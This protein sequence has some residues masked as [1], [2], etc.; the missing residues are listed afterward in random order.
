MAPVMLDF[1]ELGVAALFNMPPTE[2][3]TGQRGDGGEMKHAG[4]KKRRGW[5]QVKRQRGRRRWG[6]EDVWRRDGVRGIKVQKYN[7]GDKMRVREKPTK[8]KVQRRK[9]G[10][11]TSET[12]GL[13]WKKRSKWEVEAWE[14]D[15]RRGGNKWRRERVN[16]QW[17]RKWELSPQICVRCEGE[18]EEE[19][20]AE[21]PG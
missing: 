19:G 16:K 13:K 8:R 6:K 12:R 3:A 17:D 21:T 20:K 5:R 7:D 9:D 1:I 4:S 15:K 10:E 2:A 11:A 14:T 18:R